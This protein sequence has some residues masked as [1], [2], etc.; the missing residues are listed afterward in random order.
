MGGNEILAVLMINKKFF[1]NLGQKYFMSEKTKE[2]LKRVNLAKE[3]TKDLQNLI[4]DIDPMDQEQT[5]I[6][7]AYRKLLVGAKLGKPFTEEEWTAFKLQA[8]K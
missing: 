5:D 6:R 2:E 1:L 8:K 4:N 3:Q 7:D